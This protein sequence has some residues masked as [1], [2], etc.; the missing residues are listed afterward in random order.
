[1]AA[2]CVPKGPIAWTL[3]LRP[4][5]WIGTISYGAYLWHYPIYI[6]FDPDR[7]GTTGFPLLVIRF[8]ATFA[9][10]T[11]SF[12]LVERPVMYGTFWRQLKAAIPATAL[13][14]VTVAV[15][16]AGTVV[17]ATAAVRVRH[18]GDPRPTAHALRTG[19][20]FKLVVLGDST[21]VTLGAALAAT[22]P[23]G[24]QVTQA[25]T[26]GCGLAIAVKTSNKPPLPGLN[27]VGACNEASPP[28]EQWPA[29]AARQVLGTTRGD[30]VLFLAG[31]WEAQ[32][33]FREG[34]WT[35]ITHPSFQRY[36]LHQMRDAVAI[37]TA[38]GAHF[39]FTTMPVMDAALPFMDALFPVDS[40]NRRHIYDRLITDVAH[41]F[42]D[43]VSVLDLGAILSPHGVFTEFLDGV[44]IRTPDGVHTPSYDPGIPY[45]DNTTQSV[46]NAFYNW[47]SPRI[48]PSIIASSRPAG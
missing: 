33:L 20:P 29:L 10:A 48:W 22:A 1:V 17:P 4:L 37:G 38:H 8:A 28:S 39:D 34:T 2:V 14:V 7:T 41:E 23:S 19:H 42:P 43:K 13:L 25:G 44:Q 5:V 31:D 12:Y 46:A 35:N 11:A 18:F 36:L 40:P 15:V 26:Y 45:A 27:M 24:I 30:V 32:D 21:A 9:L 47:L 3:S 6:Y 16:I